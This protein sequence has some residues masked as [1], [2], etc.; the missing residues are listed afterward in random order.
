MPE[1]GTTALGRAGARLLRTRALMRAPVLLY[2]ARLGALLGPRLLLL[3]H[4]GRNSGMARRV[5]LE[6]LATP[7]PDV[8]V[9]ASGFGAR[10]Q[11]YRNV[12]ANPQ[13]RVSTG[14]HR[15]RPATARRLTTAEADAMLA[16]YARRHPRAWAK[17][18][19]VLRGTLGEEVTERDTA[20][21][22]F[23][24]RPR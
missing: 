14:R 15:D 17:F 19:D 13:V 7:E 8:H 11:W 4:V 23:E 18:K 21:P 1:R 10:A 20:L 9:V 3:E 2:R 6:V 16:D 24:L 22:M 5:V 12:V